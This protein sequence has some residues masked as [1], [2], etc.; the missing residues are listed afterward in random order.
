MVCLTF[1]AMTLSAVS[2]SLTELSQGVSDREK[3]IQA[4]SLSCH[5]DTEL[6]E[7]SLQLTFVASE[8]VEVRADSGGRLRYES[9]GDVKDGNGARKDRTIGVFNGTEAR[10]MRSLGADRFLVGQIDAA[11]SG[12]YTRFDPWE[13][14]TAYFR[15]PVSSYLAQP[16]VSLIGTE[17]WDGRAAQVVEIQHDLLPN[18]SD[19]RKSR[20]WID[21]SRGFAVVKR[22]T[23]ARRTRADK[24]VEYYRAEG[25]NHSEVQ[26]GIWLPSEVRL[27]TVDL[28]P[29]DVGQPKALVSHKIRVKEWRLNPAFGD[30]EFTFAFVERIN[31]EDH[32]HGTTFQV[33]TVTDQNIADQLKLDPAL[34]GRS[35][36]RRNLHAFL[37]FNLSL[38]ILLSSVFAYKHFK[39]R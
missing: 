8:D 18:G 31:V 25:F 24:W 6:R 23:L 34:G 27:T 13:F 3:A 15:K 36:Q 14:V 10:S 4:F 26:P 39:K 12:L 28:T 7:Q 2:P 9:S 38:A 5:A 33:S 21:P 22:A 17:T 37:Y 19:Y 35:N 16:K 29:E 32:I 1:L 30:S 11:P 20:F